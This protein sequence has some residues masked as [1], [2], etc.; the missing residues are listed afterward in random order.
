MGWSL[1]VWVGCKSVSNFALLPLLPL[2]P[3]CYHRWVAP[4]ARIGK[5]FSYI[6][7][8]TATENKKKRYVEREKRERMCELSMSPP[9]SRF[10]GSIGSI[11]LNL[12]IVIDLECYFGR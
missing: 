8:S 1:S 11:L 5:R 10:F 2:L 12:L 3:P 6:Y 9:L 4:L 7:I